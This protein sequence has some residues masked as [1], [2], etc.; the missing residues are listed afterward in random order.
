MY[1]ATPS[2]F[3]ILFLE[4]F[5]E[6]YMK[7]PRVS[8][9]LIDIQLQVSVPFNKALLRTKSCSDLE[10]AG[11]RTWTSHILDHYLTMCNSFLF[12]CSVVSL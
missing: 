4:G 11:K 12:S 1:H 5:P 7:I 3:T 9:S 8:H 2:S 6:N 10:K